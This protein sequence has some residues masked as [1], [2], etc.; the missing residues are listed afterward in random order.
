MSFNCE[1]QNRHSNAFLDLNGIPYVLAEYLDKNCFRS[2]DRSMILSDIQIDQSE[3]MRAVVDISIDDIGKR[4][5]GLPAIVGNNTKQKKLMN[6]IMNGAC[7]N[8]QLNVVKRGIIMRINYQLENARTHVVLRTMV[9]D[10]RITDRLYFLDINPR[11][12]DDN[13]IITNFTHAAVSTINQFTH[14]TDKMIFKITS[15]QM[16]YECVQPSPKVPR[17]KQSLASCNPGGNISEYPGEGCDPYFYHD[18]HQNHHIIGPGANNNYGAEGVETISPNSWVLF[19]RFYHFDNNGA[20]IIFHN[21]EINDPMTKTVL[22]PCGTILVERTFI[23]N[24][25][26][27]IIFK[28]SVWKNDLTVVYDTSAIANALGAPSFGDCWNP[29]HDHHPHPHPDHFPPYHPE[30]DAMLEECISKMRQ[31]SYVLQNSISMLKDTIKV[32]KRQEVSISKLASE[33]RSLKDIVLKYH[34]DDN[35][36]DESPSGCECD[37][38]EIENKIEEIETI[39]DNLKDKSCECGEALTIDEVHAMVEQFK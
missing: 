1:H 37:H 35:V 2:I 9:E 26:H 5:D 14:G 27:R 20:D 24:P 3:S 22:I 12:I 6:L 18:K 25:G 13:A 39:V 28:F 4:S 36:D 17:I 34:P 16:F 31:I 33:V 10:I 7:Q 29:S 15:I 38:T 23:I 30:H 8:N 32:N 21:D 11:N 19:N